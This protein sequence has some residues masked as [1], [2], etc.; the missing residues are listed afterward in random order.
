MYCTRFFSY[1]IYTSHHNF[2]WSKYLSSMKYSLP[3]SHFL[4]VSP[5]TLLSVERFEYITRSQ[6]GC[7]LFTYTLWISFC[8]LTFGEA[9]VV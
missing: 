5:F 7:K 9:G 6:Y 2:L 4:H 1:M 8:V 3:P